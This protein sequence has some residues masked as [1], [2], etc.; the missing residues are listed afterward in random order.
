MELDFAMLALGAD[1]S[2]SGN[3]HL[4]NAG[5]DTMNVS[6]VP[7]FG[8]SFS[9]V[10]RFKSSREE[11]GS[12][13]ALEIRIIRPNGEWKDAGGT[14]PP[15]TVE[16]NPDS[17]EDARHTL[18]IAGINMEFLSEGDIRLR[19]GSM[20][21][22]ISRFHWQSKSRLSKTIDILCSSLK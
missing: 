4:F 17:P 14:L 1:K 10:A 13:H 20:V 6:H 12:T 16:A 11:I 2:E 15:I 18:I 7:I 5:F 3:L 9:L 21:S 19:S 8:P 22:F